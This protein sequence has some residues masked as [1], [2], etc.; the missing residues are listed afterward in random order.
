[1]KDIVV[2][3]VVALVVSAV[4][5]ACG[6]TGGRAVSRDGTPISEATR[7]LGK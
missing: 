7:A 4:L 1:M 3:F 6:C 5:A 2:T